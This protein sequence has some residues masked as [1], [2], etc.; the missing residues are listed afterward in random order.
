MKN[1]E[2]GD[3]DIFTD[4]DQGLLIDTGDH[5]HVKLPKNVAF[6]ENDFFTIEDPGVGPSLSIL[7]YIDWCVYM[8]EALI[9]PLLAVFTHSRVQ[10]CTHAHTYDDAPL[11]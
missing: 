5:K 8:F 4:E 10:A 6:S 11:W 9:G 2:F 1:F 3:N 7:S